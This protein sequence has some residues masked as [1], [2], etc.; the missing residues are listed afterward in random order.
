MLPSLLPSLIVML[1]YSSVAPLRPHVLLVLA[2]DVGW[3]NLGW[4]ARTNAARAEVST[5]A[6]NALVAEGIELERAIAFKYC[7]PSRC[8]LQSGRNPI[9]VNVHNDVFGNST[10]IPL[11]MTC[12]ASKLKLAGYRTIA[13]GKWHAGMQHPG[14]TPRGRGYDA[15]LTYFNPDNDYWAN[16]YSSC[17]VTPNSTVKTPI[18]DLWEAVEGAGEGPAFHRNNSCPHDR[19]F[20]PNNGCMDELGRR[21]APQW[22]AASNSQAGKLACIRCAMEANITACG[23]P[24]NQSAQNQRSIFTAVPNRLPSEIVLRWCDGWRAFTT[25]TGC[26]NP[27]ANGSAVYEDELFARYLRAAVATH[28]N[29]VPL[30]VFFAPHSAHTPMQAQEATLE[31]FDFISRRGDDKPEHTRQTYTAMVAEGDAA[32]GAVVDEFRSKGLWEHTLMI[33]SSDNVH[34]Q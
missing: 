9:H 2:D 7:S 19:T 32:I 26:R 21:C 29:S 14:Q 20:I 17:P 8:A 12:L 11:K 33:Y 34:S 23:A 10:G 24:I 31:R 15:A 1:P 18:V 5:P 4:H 25:G 16:T 27:H 6:L 13:A 30:L 28:E 3:N 22:D